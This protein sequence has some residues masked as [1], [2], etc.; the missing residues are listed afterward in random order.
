MNTWIRIAQVI[1][2]VTYRICRKWKAT[3]LP[4]ASLRT[5]RQPF[6]KY[7]K[8]GKASRKA[9]LLLAKNQFELWLICGVDPNR[10]CI[11]KSHTRWLFV[12]TSQPR[13]GQEST[14]QFPLLILVQVHST[15]LWRCRTLP[16][17]E[18]VIQPLW[19]TIVAVV[20][21]RSLRLFR[22]RSH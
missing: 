2:Y 12:A 3:T 7:S 1:I 22:R 10:C 5:S 19:M 4:G 9:L 18:T 11:Y 14:L 8:A 16:S 20:A 17:Y 13:I 21:R 15:H 6:R